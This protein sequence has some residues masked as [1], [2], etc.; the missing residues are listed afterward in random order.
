MGR[1]ESIASKR[2]RNMFELAKQVAPQHPD[3][4]QRYAEIARRIA[5][6]TR[7]KVPSEYKRLIC[8]HCKRFMLPGV[9]CRVRIRQRREPHVA[10]TCFFCGNVTRIPLGS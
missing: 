6:R 5:Q 1:I 7:V 9:S 4:A 3:L 8:K 10:I 2:I